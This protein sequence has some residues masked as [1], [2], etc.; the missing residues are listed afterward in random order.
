[1]ARVKQPVTIGLDGS[2]VKRIDRLAKA[3][4]QSRSAWIEGQIRD[5]IDN[6]ELGI[7]VLTDP[8]TSTVFASLFKDRDTLRG[9]A[10]LLGEQLTDDQLRLFTD[11]VEKLVGKEKRASKVKPGEQW[12]P[13]GRRGKR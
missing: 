2:L 1:M 12:P 7:Q 3:V 13:R 11:R 5:A 6:E 9:F 8:V 10:R 4:G